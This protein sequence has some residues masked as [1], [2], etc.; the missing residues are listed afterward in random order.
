MAQTR[1][2]TRPSKTRALG[3]DKTGKIAEMTFRE[4]WAR[5]LQI[6]LFS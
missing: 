3:E 1:I 4:V 2:Y 6:L 5:N